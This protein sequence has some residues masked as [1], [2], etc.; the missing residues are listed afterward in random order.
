MKEFHFFA[1]NVATWI[2]TTDQRTLPEVIRYMEQDGYIYSLW[3]VPGPWDSEYL[4]N[5][6]APQVEGAILIGTYTPAKHPSRKKSVAR[7]NRTA[8]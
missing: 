8:V 4:I 2:A 3:M 5:H 7:E 6:Y 1:S